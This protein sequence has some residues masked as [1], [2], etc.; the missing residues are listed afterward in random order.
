MW[1]SRCLSLAEEH[2]TFLHPVLADQYLFVLVEAN[3]LC[4][5]GDGLEVP[6]EGP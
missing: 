1:M 5:W 4:A 3:L 2:A 6:C